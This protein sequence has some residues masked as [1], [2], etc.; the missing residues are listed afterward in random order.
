MIEVHTPN[1]VSIGSGV[2][3][4]LRI[5]TDRQTDRQTDRP[6]YSVCK[7]RQHLR[8]SAMQPKTHV[9]TS[10]NF[11]CYLWPWL[12]PPSDGNA[13]RYVLPVLWMTS[14]FHIVGQMQIQTW[15]LR[16]IELFTVIRQVAPLN[17]EP[18][19]EVCYRRLP[20]LACNLRDVT[21][22][23]LYLAEWVVVIVQLTRDDRRPGSN[24]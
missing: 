6:R 14:R 12:G 15:S 4:G 24:T 9:Q 18:G 10:R 22:V 13:I 7:N 1:G 3:A 17:C 20:C 2:F 23:R 8:S 19:D 21:S 5:V 16:R 11:V